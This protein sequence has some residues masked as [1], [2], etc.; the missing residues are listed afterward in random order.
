MALQAT[1]F[2]IA[3]DLLPH[4][5]VT[6]PAAY[7]AGTIYPDSRYVSGIRRSLTHQDGC[8]LD[9]FAPGLT[10]F[11][12]GWAVHLVYDEVAGEPQKGLIPPHIRN[13]EGL[14]DFWRHFTIVKFLEDEATCVALGSALAEMQSIH[15]L[16]G[17]PRHEP[18]EALERFYRMVRDLYANGPPSFDAHARYFDGLVPKETVQRLMADY[19]TAREDAELVARSQAIY[20]RA[21]TA[22]LVLKP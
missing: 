6:D 20:A 16:G 4:L 1:H 14:G 11:E 5:P 2:R 13:E 15:P 8:P 17:T 7:Y 21:R 12:R 10:D 19:R 9:P 22:I 3:R 18:P